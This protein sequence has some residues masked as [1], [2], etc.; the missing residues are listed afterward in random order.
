MAID[1]GALRK[2]E[3][4][5]KPILDAIPAVVSMVQ[6]Q[7]DLDRSIAAKRREFE[8]AEQEIKDAYEE[9][10]K[11]LIALNA[12][13]ERIMACN[14]DY[15]EQTAQL[16]TARDREISELVSNRRKSITT[17]E[18]KL[19]DAESKLAAVEADIAQKQATFDAE[20]KAKTSAAETALADIEKRR[21]AAET[22]LEAIRAKLG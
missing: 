11:R 2:F 8:E 20:V 10:N 15:E 12:E 6:Q 13:M 9:A 19:A 1:I 5:W 21:Q 16:V 4:T 14:K 18:K 3:D 7:N 22:A 17:V